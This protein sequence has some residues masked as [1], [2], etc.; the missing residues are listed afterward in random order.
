MKYVK[1]I[2]S[3]LG[4]DERVLNI[5]NE[6]EFN[7]AVQDC[8]EEAKFHEKYSKRNYPTITLIAVDGSYC[9]Q[10]L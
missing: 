3:K 2:E 5:E 4:T 9:R 7:N 6:Q 1:K 10:F 8:K